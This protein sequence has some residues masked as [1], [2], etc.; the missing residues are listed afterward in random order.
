[1]MTFDIVDGACLSTSPTSVLSHLAAYESHETAGDPGRSTPTRPRCHR[2]L[3]RSCARVRRKGLVMVGTHEVEAIGNGDGAAVYVRLDKKLVAPTRSQAC[4]GSSPATITSSSTQTQLSRPPTIRKLHGERAR[5]VVGTCDN[6][7]R[8]GKPEP[9]RGF[10]P[11]ISWCAANATAQRC[12]SRHVHETVY[13][14]GDLPRT[15]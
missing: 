6:S 15:V 4:T 10:T 2:V 7:V 9:F 14:K 12:R 3:Q 1:M 11:T 5:V 13:M 8:V